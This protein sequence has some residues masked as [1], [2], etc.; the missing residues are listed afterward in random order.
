[1]YI[2]PK[3]PNHK[4]FRF[5]WNT[6]EIVDENGLF[7]DSG[8]GENYEGYV[9]CAECKFL[10]SINHINDKKGEIKWKDI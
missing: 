5:Y 2:C 1:M 9:Y 10:V 4:T 3:N 8:P 6:Y 7:I